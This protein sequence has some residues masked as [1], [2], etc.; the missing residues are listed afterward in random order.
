MTD[1]GIDDYVLRQLLNL[2]CERLFETDLLVSKMLVEDR[3]QL[4]GRGNR[5]T[6]AA[7][8]PLCTEFTKEIRQHIQAAPLRS[9]EDDLLLEE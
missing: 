4:Q 9:Q 6:A 3:I 7:Y 5:I 1:F 2:G 8:L